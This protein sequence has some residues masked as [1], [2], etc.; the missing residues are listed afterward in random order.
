MFRGGDT[1]RSK[2]VRRFLK[3]AVPP[4]PTWMTLYLRETNFHCH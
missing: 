1:E 4:V 3:D 2:I